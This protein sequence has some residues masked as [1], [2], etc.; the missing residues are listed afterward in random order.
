MHRENGHLLDTDL[1]MTAGLYGFHVGVILYVAR[2]G[3]PPDS[4]FKKRWERTRSHTWSHI[5]VKK[6]K[7]GVEVATFIGRCGAYRQ[8]DTG[9]DWWQPCVFGRHATIF[10]WRMGKQGWESSLRATQLPMLGDWSFLAHAG[11]HSLCYF[12]S[13]EKGKGK[14]KLK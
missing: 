5:E 9:S 13:S 6:W 10:F 4:R 14:K 3:E 11:I 12:H 1:Y 8:W 2:T 7:A